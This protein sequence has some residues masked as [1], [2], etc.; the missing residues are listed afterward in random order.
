MKKVN[1]LYL[2]VIMVL[3]AAV[4]ALATP[5]ESTAG[6]DRF[7]TV[8]YDEIKFG[9]AITVIQDKETGCFYGQTSGTYHTTTFPIYEYADRIHCEE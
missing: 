9:N 4:I 5:K 1:H 6:Y 2:L 3:I 7:K 8:G